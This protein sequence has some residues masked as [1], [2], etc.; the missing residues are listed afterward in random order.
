MRTWDSWL[1]PDLRD[2]IATEEPQ[3]F[4]RIV[5]AL[6]SDVQIATADLSP[7]AYHKHVLRWI[8][9]VNK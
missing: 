6:Q 1:D 5:Q 3:R 4:K 8:P 2:A 9:I 7:D